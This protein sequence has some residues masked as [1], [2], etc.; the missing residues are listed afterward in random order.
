MTNPFKQLILTNECITKS[1]NSRTDSLLSRFLQFSFNL[2][3]HKILKTFPLKAASRLAIS[4]YNVQDSA[5]YVATG[6]INV[7]WIFI[8]FTPFRY[9]DE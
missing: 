1:P 2:I 3:P 6:F 5:Q 8:F 7:L 9:K 4:T